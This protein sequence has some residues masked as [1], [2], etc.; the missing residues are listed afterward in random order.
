MRAASYEAWVIGKI[1]KAK[2]KTVGTPALLRVPKYLHHQLSGANAAERE[3]SRMRLAGIIACTSR[4]W[5][6][7]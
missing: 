5:W 3:L 6:L 1:Q 2:S 7:R 4:R